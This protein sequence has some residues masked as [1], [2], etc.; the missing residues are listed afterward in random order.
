MCLY[1]NTIKGYVIVCFYMDNMLILSNNE[2]M[3]KST[4]KILTNK[5]SI[6]DLGIVDVLL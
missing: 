6:K 2:Y 5:F 3:I 4:N 1:K